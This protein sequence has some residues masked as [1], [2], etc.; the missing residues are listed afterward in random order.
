MCFVYDY[1]P[2]FCREAAPKAKKTHQCTA[3]RQTIQVGAHY[4]E[5]VYAEDGAKRVVSEKWCRRCVYDLLRVVKHELEEGCAWYEAWPC[6]ADL[7]EYLT[8]SDLGQTPE[9]AVPEGFTLDEFRKQLSSHQ[10]GEEPW[11][12]SLEKR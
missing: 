6:A 1:T 8:Q 4:R 11:Q 5:L 3:C 10:S 2:A 9:E 7:V 12:S